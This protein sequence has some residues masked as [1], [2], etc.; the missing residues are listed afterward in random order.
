MRTLK[1]SVNVFFFA[2]HIHHKQQINCIAFWGFDVFCAARQRSVESDI[3][4]G[5]RE[6]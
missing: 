1:I 3:E 2:R 6:L 5:K 4:V